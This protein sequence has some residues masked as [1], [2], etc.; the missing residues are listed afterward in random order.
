MLWLLVLL[1]PVSCRVPLG[2][3]WLLFLLSSA[4]SGRTVGTSEEP[5]RPV[6]DA[7]APA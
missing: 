4:V 7:V 6:L 1:S 3:L 5:R 2:V